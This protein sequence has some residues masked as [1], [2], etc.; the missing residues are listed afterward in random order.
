[1]ETAYERR[2]QQALAYYYANRERLCAYQR[3]YHQA[4]KERV[5]EYNN[6]Y[7]E[8]VTKW[9]REPKPPKPKKEKVPKVKTTIKYHSG[10][11]TEKRIRV[12]SRKAIPLPPAPVA[13]KWEGG[14]ID[15]D[16]L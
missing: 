2:R 13:V 16:K 4:N 5:S 10:A 6:Y 1:M 8:T 7:Y 3:A 15:W 11:V 12:R 9:V 14:V